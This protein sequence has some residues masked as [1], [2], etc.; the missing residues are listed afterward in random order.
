VFEH[1]ADRHL[2]Q[3][4]VLTFTDS[5]NLA[6]LA[7]QGPHRRVLVPNVPQLNLCDLA[8]GVMRNSVL[9]EWEHGKLPDELTTNGRTDHIDRK[10]G[11]A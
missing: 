5:I 2:A 1:S 6:P 11:R 9:L 8:K 7:D 4:C 10:F 3:V